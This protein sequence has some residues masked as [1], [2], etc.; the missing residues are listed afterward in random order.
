VKRVLSTI[1]LL[2]LLATPVGAAPKAKQPQTPALPKRFSGNVSWYGVPFHGRRT[3]SG[4]IF[5][6]TKL[7]SAHKTLPFY[8]K[9]LVENPRNGKTVIVSVLDRGPF[10]ANRVMDLSREAAR[11]LGTL[12]GGVAWVDCIIVNDMPDRPAVPKGPDDVLPS[13]PQPEAE[14]KESPKDQESPKEAPAETRE[15]AP[16]DRQST[17]LP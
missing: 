7:S 15:A 13:V 12:L 9:V 10:V 5:D 6:M 4:R 11:Q 14:T 3:A 2:T 16:N 8:T 1:C 17:P